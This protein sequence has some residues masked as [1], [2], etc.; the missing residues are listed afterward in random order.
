MKGRQVI[1]LISLILLFISYVYDTNM[2]PVENLEIISGA[3]YDLLKEAD[4]QITYSIPLST[5]VFEPD[6]K[7]SVEIKTGTGNT[8]AETRGDRQRKSDKKFLL[9]LEKVYVISEDFARYGIRSILDILFSNPQVNDMGAVVVYKG[10]AEELLSY[11]IKG[12]PTAADYLEGLINNAPGFNFFTNKYKLMDVFACVDS[13]GRRAI[14]PYIE[15][16]KKGPEVTGFAVFS[17]DTMIELIDISQ[18]TALNLLRENKVSGSLRIQK[19]AKNYVDFYGKTIRKAKTSRNG[20]NYCFEIDLLLEGDITSIE[21]LPSVIDNP[22]LKKKLE[23]E[24]ADAVKIM[25]DEFIEKMKNEYKLDLLD[26]GRI[27]AAKYGRHENKDWDK[28]V[29]NSNIKVTVK[30]KIQ[31]EGRGNY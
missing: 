16:K 5:Y 20:E 13:E 31:K 3:G 7:I 14:I 6:N 25:C 17:K 27:A 26:L 10:S 9:G 23:E 4:G 12:Y 29:C 18:G 11:Q 19:D 28:I 24:F 30:V 15:L 1:I 2:K 22:E 21:G 8:I